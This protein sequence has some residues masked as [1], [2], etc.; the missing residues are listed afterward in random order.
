MHLMTKN[1]RNLRINSKNLS[2]ANYLLIIICFVIFSC[3]SKDKKKIE[4]K[5]ITEKKVINTKKDQVI[6]K[7][8][9]LNLQP[10]K[11]EGIA[12]VLGRDIKF[13]DV[14]QLETDSSPDYGE[15]FEILEVS[16]GKYPKGN[17]YH[18]E[19]FP[20][21]HISNNRING[22]LS[23]KYVYRINNDSD[24]KI[25]ISN[26]P[27]LIYH[28]DGFGIGSIDSTGSFTGCLEYYPILLKSVNR[29]TYHNINLV[30][31]T[32]IFHTVQS[33]VFYDA[34]K[35]IDVHTDSIATILKIKTE[36][37]EGGHFFDL[38]L[39]IRENNLVFGKISN[40]NEWTF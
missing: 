13:Y 38:T 16:E 17:Q 24:K 37:M 10:V 20:Y 21:I 2:I 22:W 33:L 6:E 31:E 3:N 28:S 18:C 32:K 23:G 14:N 34:D 9:K 1:N 29:D 26:D 15:I 8:E 40:V 7:H 5:V 39:S 11:S 19:Q 27:Y 25:V 35:I 36:G 4:T 30:G 12:V